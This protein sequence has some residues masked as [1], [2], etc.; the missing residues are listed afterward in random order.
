MADEIEDL[1]NRLSGKELHVPDLLTILGDWKTDINSH[2]GQ[3]RPLRYQQPREVHRRRLFAEIEFYISEVVTE[4][5]RQH[6][7]A[8]PNVDEYLQMRMGTS[9]MLVFLAFSD[10]MNK[11]RLPQ[12]IMEKEEM[13]T[14]KNETTKLAMF[15]NDI[16][17]LQKEIVSGAPQ[18]IVPLLLNTSSTKTLDERM[19]ELITMICV[20]VQKFEEALR[21]LDAATGEDRTLHN[22]LHVY[23]DNCRTLVTGLIEWSKKTR[24]YSLGQYEVRGGGFKIPL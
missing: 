5:A 17:S 2:L 23:A 8:L 21:N 24:R 3:L 10:Y 22:S 6:D 18:N 20:S 15:V 4:H 7:R 1:L 14:L 11:M 12:W 9:G 16:Y 19:D 13:A